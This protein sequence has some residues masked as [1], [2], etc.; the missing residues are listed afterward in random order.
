MTLMVCLTFSC[1][2]NWHFHYINSPSPNNKTGIHLGLWIDQDFGESDRISIRQAVDQ[3]NYAMN[4]WV[5]LDIKRWDFD[6][7]VQEI[8]DCQKSG[9]WMIMKIDGS[10]PMIHDYPGHFVLAFVDSLRGHLMYVIRNRIN[11]DQVSGIVMHEIG[12]L[13]GSGH[14]KNGLMYFE[15]H[16]DSSRCVDRGTVTEVAKSWHIDVKNLNYCQYSD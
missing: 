11:N 14:L 12:H 2:E 1:A 9:G 3:W 4:G 5:I 6:M 8:L 7:S 13:M 16:A 10:N 15:F